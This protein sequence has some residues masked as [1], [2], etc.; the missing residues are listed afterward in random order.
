MQVNRLFH[1]L[2]LALSFI[3]AY[4]LIGSLSPTRCAAQGPP[5]HSALHWFFGQKA[6]FSFAIPPSD[7][8]PIPRTDGNMEAEAACAVASDQSGP[9]FY[10]NGSSV[11]NKEHEVMSNGDNLGF[12]AQT[13]HGVV[14]VPDPGNP[15]L[16]Y[17]FYTTSIE[18]YEERKDSLSLRYAI[19][20]LSANGD[21]GAVIRK[22]ILLSTPNVPVTEHLAAV[23]HSNGTDYWLIAHEANSNNFLT[24]RISPGSIS[25]RAITSAAGNR[26]DFIRQRRELRGMIKLEPRSVGNVASLR[27]AVTR[28]GA[29][30]F[31][32]FY[33]AASS[34]RIS[35]PMAINSPNLYGVEFS[36]SGEYLYA[37]QAD[38]SDIIRFNI[39]KSTAGEISNSRESVGTA[40]G[41]VGSI[42]LGPDGR[43]YIASAGE[44]NLSMIRNPNAKDPRFQFASAS[45]N[46]RKSSLG[47]P[48]VLPHAL[49]DCFNI[50]EER[51]YICKKA[52]TLTLR[53]CSPRP[54][55]RMQWFNTYNKEIPGATADTLRVTEGGYYKCRF[56]RTSTG[57]VFFSNEIDIPLRQSLSMQL[58][59]SPNLN[60]DPYSVGQQTVVTATGIAPGA[61]AF[62]WSFPGAN[63]DTSNL[64]EPST[65]YSGRGKYWIK[66][67]I[68][69]EEGCLSEDSLLINVVPFPT[70]QFRDEYLASAFSPNGDGLNDVYPLYSNHL[71]RFDFYVFD[72]TGRL[73]YQT[74]NRFN[75]YWDGN[76][77]GN[78]LPPG[79][80][81][82]SMRGVNRENNDVE[83]KGTITL[84]R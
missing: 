20:D 45:L 67:G 15:N 82:Y 43:I 39:G 29:S 21:K 3:L 10:T 22:S 47:L 70:E 79:V 68:I 25:P 9:L 56:T 35:D 26:Y 75:S 24:Y 80:Y 32:L 42:Q 36:P 54:G 48:N 5:T 51:N 27:M 78:P 64:R 18:K 23:R 58:M 83:Y 71:I 33:F 59:V 62:R 12:G 37:T 46:A 74:N 28:Q 11:W 7:R 38:N 1:V 17:I 31:E 8:Q 4:L 61:E 41:K 19:V 53:I 69:D 40:F 81:S 50:D 57:E 65:V 84:V 55:F 60:D 77:N 6:G 66:L 52:D 73:V 30:N 63:P 34:G 76:S 16:Y 2:P 44:G 13:R 14:T 49:D 72:R